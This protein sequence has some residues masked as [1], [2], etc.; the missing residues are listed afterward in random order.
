MKRNR[1]R[2]ALLR[3][4]RTAATSGL[5]PVDAGNRPWRTIHIHRI[6][7]QL[8]LLKRQPGRLRQRVQ[9]FAPGR[10]ST[11]FRIVRDRNAENEQCLGTKNSRRLSQEVQERVREHVIIVETGGVPCA[12]PTSVQLATHAEKNGLTSW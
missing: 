11:R 1:W 4:P 8:F 7:T 9:S 3:T 6:G 5:R 10:S 12:R 2:A